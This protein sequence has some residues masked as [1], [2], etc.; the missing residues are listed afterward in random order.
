MNFRRSTTTQGVLAD[1]PL[2]GLVALA[3]FFSKQL[4][5]TIAVLQ[6]CVEDERVVIALDRADRDKAF[7]ETYLSQFSASIGEILQFARRRVSTQNEHDISNR[8]FQFQTLSE[9]VVRNDIDVRRNRLYA[10]CDAFVRRT[11]SLHFGIDSVA[12]GVHAIMFDCAW[13]AT[14]DACESLP[15]QRQEVAPVV[16]D[17]YAGLRLHA[18]EYARLD[19]VV[20]FSMAHLGADVCAQ[21]ELGVT[22]SDFAAQD[23]D[24]DGVVQLVGRLIWSAP[25]LYNMLG[26]A[27]AT[28]VH[29]L[30]LAA[31]RAPETWRMNAWALAQVS[32]TEKEKKSDLAM[33]TDAMEQHDNTIYPAPA[34]F[35]CVAFPIALLAY[36]VVCAPRDAHDIE[37]I[38]SLIHSPIALGAMERNLQKFKDTFLNY[39]PDLDNDRLCKYEQKVSVL[40]CRAIDAFFRSCCRD[41]AH[42]FAKPATLKR[43]AN[44]S[45]SKDA[46][47]ARQLTTA[48]MVSSKA[49][50]KKSRGDGSDE[51]DD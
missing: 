15:P 9:A 27:V 24:D 19:H 20:A 3:H 28:T 13:A 8:R 22:E 48:K 51:D 16:D 17:A 11:V 47:G 18:E 35:W 42:R 45:K 26:D 36:A 29:D 6:S 49:K 7:M 14:G 2:P 23:D 34:F 33:I 4:Q 43:S 50:R 31:S 37:R 32:A 41:L 10:V 21:Y 38:A 40:A 25:A 39:P 46:G 12:K 44:S 30:K 5:T 1:V